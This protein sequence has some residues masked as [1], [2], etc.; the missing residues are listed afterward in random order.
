MYLHRDESVEEH[1]EV[2]GGI[3]DDEAESLSSGN[4]EDII[5]EIEE[6]DDEWGPDDFYH[7]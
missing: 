2:C 3:D 1:L 7:R 5:D 4:Y 6:E